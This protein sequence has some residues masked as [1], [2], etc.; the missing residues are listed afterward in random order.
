MYKIINATGQV[1]GKTEAPY[2]I[3]TAGKTG[4]SPRARSGRPRD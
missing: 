4:A 3:K 1:V 2:Y